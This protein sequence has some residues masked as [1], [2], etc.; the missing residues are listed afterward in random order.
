MPFR[1]GFALQSTFAAHTHPLGAA[2][3]TADVLQ[4]AG[5][6]ANVTADDVGALATDANMARQTG[7]LSSS[8]IILSGPV[9]TNNC[10]AIGCDGASL[11]A[12][13]IA[14]IAGNGPVGSVAWDKAAV[15]TD[16]P[17][18]AR[19]DLVQ[20]SGVSKVAA[21]VTAI[22]ANTGAPN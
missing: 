9:A 22:P 3:T 20:A 5:A 17:V 4:A 14:Q 21:V 10:A 18:T 8:T 6:P 1:P 15:V 7:V 2:T 16:V 11:N 19:A 13:G 12:A